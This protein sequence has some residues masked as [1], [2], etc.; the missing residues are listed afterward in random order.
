MKVGELWESIQTKIQDIAPWDRRGKIIKITGLYRDD[1]EM[2]DYVEYIVIED[3][4]IYEY[5]SDKPTGGIMIR[6]ELL[7]YYKRVQNG[8]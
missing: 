7:T 2:E 6:E 4:D 5:E 3:E 1:E 8:L